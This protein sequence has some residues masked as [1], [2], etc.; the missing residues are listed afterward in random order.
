MKILSLNYNARVGRENNFKPNLGMT[1][2][3]GIVTIMVLE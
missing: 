1:V 2:Y 3:N